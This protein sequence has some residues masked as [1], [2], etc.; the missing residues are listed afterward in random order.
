MPEPTGSVTTRS[1][2]G[3]VPCLDPESQPN[4][5][6]RLGQLARLVE[7]LDDP[8][9][10]AVVESPGGTVVLRRPARS[11][12]S[13]PRFRRST[14]PRRTPVPPGRRA[15]PTRSQKPTKRSG[16]TCESQKPKKTTSKTLRA[17]S[18]TG[19]PGRGGRG[20]GRGLLQPGAVDLQDLREASTATITVCVAR[21][22]HRPQARAAREF[23]HVAFGPEPPEVVADSS[24][25]ENHRRLPFGAEVVTA[26]AINHSSYS[27]ARAL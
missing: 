11:V 13:R 22:L 3:G 5:R 10:P 18:R 25:C 2:K 26:P 4:P 9:L 21:E 14:S 19:L 24:N 8:E 20:S 1:R 12:P 7:D 16:G 23:Q 15:E 17:A 6:S 27:A